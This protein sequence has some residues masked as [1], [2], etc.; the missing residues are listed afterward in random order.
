M[1]GLMLGALGGAGQEL[2]KAGGRMQQGAID[3]DLENLRNENLLNRA[4]ALEQFKMDVGNQQRVQMTERVGAAKTGLINAEIDNRY[5]KPVMGDTP[6]TEEQQAVL[7]QGLMQQGR[8]I[9]ADRKT[10]EGDVGMDVKAALKT[11]D[12]SVKDAA[13]LSQ[14]DAANETRLAIAQ[15]RTDALNAKTE[16]QYE[17]AMAKLNLALSKA[18]GK[19]QT[20]KEMLSLLDGMRKDIASESTDIKKTMDSEIQGLG[21]FAEPEEV[22]KVRDAYA[23]KLQLIEKRRA[24]I[25]RDFNS[26]RTRMGLDPI[27]DDS[28]PESTAPAKPP[29]SAKPA[30]VIPSLPAGSKKIG[31]SNG[32]D[33]YQA[34]DGKRYIAQ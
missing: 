30:A 21:K 26:L 6:L 14:K 22:K 20:N 15:M 19:D 28:E 7:D 18:S 4:K 16:A 11:G 24:Q 33:V 12:L 9:A 5:A 13:T 32:K 25:Q 8:D 1:A 27:Q 31:T 17:A 3:A 23:P 2:A 29:A 10:L 34:P